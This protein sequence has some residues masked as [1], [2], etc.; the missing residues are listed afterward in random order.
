M[1]IVSFGPSGAKK[2]D[3]CRDMNGY[4]EGDITFFNIWARPVIDDLTEKK[5]VEAIVPKVFFK[6]EEL[7]RLFGFRRND[8]VDFDEIS[9]PV[10]TMLKQILGDK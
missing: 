4:S 1:K 9:K 6:C 5:T 3:A 7:D 2:D 10:Y 8:N